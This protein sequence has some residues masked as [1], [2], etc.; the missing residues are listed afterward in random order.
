MLANKLNP[1]LPQSGI[2]NSNI[3]KSSLIVESVDVSTQTPP[4]TTCATTFQKSSCS[5]SNTCKTRSMA[6]LKL[7]PFSSEPVVIMN[8]MNLQKKIIKF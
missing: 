7:L 5:V 3:F 6:E 8:I 2:F 4:V 1:K